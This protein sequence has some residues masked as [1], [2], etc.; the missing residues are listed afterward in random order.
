MKRTEARC[1]INGLVIAEVTINN[2][3]DMPSMEATYALLEH[4]SEAPLTHGK[5][6][7]NQSNWSGRT[8]DL[9]EELIHS[10]GEDLMQVHFNIEGKETIDGEG[11]ELGGAEGPPQV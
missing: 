8:M 5:C 7:A 9:M 6:T 2:F 11:T 1:K 4:G 3:T 10:M